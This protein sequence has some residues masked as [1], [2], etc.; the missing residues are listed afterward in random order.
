ML[1]IVL[2]LFDSVVLYLS[3]S[4]LTFNQVLFFVDLQVKVIFFSKTGERATP[5]MRQAAKDYW[6]DASFAFILWR[7]EE[8][9]YWWGA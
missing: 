3:L 9:S 8:S 7:E 1:M 6:A 5:F 2:I 4:V